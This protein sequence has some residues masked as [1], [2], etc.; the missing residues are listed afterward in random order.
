MAAAYVPEA[1]DIVCLQFDPRA[2]HRPG[3]LAE[4]RA[5]LKVLIG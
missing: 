2:G 1:G 5:K 4:V 3:K